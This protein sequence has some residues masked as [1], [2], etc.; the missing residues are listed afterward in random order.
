MQQS[1]DVSFGSVRWLSFFLLQSF[2]VICAI[3]D[4]ISDLRVMESFAFK[5]AGMMK[6]KLRTESITYLVNMSFAKFV[7]LKSYHAIRDWKG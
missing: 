2:K 4:F 5:L 1:A 6:Q 3:G 7:N